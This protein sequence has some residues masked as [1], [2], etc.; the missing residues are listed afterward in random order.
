MQSSVSSQNAHACMIC[1]A[2][3]SLTV[4]GGR[5]FHF[6]HFFLKFRSIFLTF[7]Q[8]FLIFF[9]ILALRVGESPT[10][11]G[12]G[13]AT[14]DMKMLFETV[15]LLLLTRYY[16]VRVMRSRTEHLQRLFV[17]SILMGHDWVFFSSLS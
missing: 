6:P 13:Y 16:H 2:V 15:G 10:R 3:A 8:F 17:L 7:P 12:P 5:E 9:L 1:R 11:E 14:D 4:P